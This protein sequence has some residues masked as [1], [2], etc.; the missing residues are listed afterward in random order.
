[1]TVYDKISVTD[2]YGNLYEGNRFGDVTRYRD[3]DR[4]QP[5]WK[6]PGPYSGYRVTSIA[7]TDADHTQLRVNWR[8][9]SNRT[10]T[11]DWDLTP[12]TP[13]LSKYVIRDVGGD[14]ITSETSWKRGPATIQLSGSTFTT[15]P[16]N[17]SVNLLNDDFGSKYAFYQFRIA[18]IPQYKDWTTIDANTKIDASGTLKVEVRAGTEAIS[19]NQDT[20]FFSDTLSRTIKLD[21]A[22][23]EK[24]VVS[25][26]FTPTYKVQELKVTNVTDKGVGVKSAGVYR[27]GVLFKALPTDNDP[28]K[29]TTFTAN[30]ETD[31]LT[32]VVTDK[33]DLERNEPFDGWRSDDSGPVITHSVEKVADPTDRQITVTVSEP[34]SYL[35]ALPADK[36]PTLM[37]DKS[38]LVNP[39]TDLPNKA[40]YTFKLSDYFQDKQLRAAANHTFSVWAVNVDG[41]QGNDD[42]FD[43]TIDNVKPE[44]PLATSTFT[45]TYHQ[46]EYTV[47]NIKDDDNGVGI[48][49]AD[50]YRDGVLVKSL[51][52]DRTFTASKDEIDTGL[53]SVKVTD[54]A[55][56]WTVKKDWQPP[57]DRT[58]PHITYTKKESV[59]PTNPMITVKVHDDE[60]PI[61]NS[62]VVLDGIGI[63]STNASIETMDDGK[64]IVYTFHL[65]HIIANADARAAWHQIIVHATNFD[66]Q[67]TAKQYFLKVYPDIS[68][69]LRPAGEGDF[70]VAPT[71]KPVLMKLDFNEEL[72]REATFTDLDS[73]QAI[74]FDAVKIVKLMYA[75]SPKQEISDAIPFYKLGADQFLVS[76][77]GDNWVYV[78]LVDNDKKYDE[79]TGSIGASAPNTFT[80][81]PVHVKIDY[82]Q[83]QY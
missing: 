82:N 76:K 38:I 53:I 36:K 32:I 49:T 31:K 45:S 66:D 4:E 72:V 5:Q 54:L 35:P 75:V 22:P 11:E 52:N 42:P 48:A 30:K 46:Y 69:Q 73:G 67:E 55:G 77:E 79:S 61:H 26:K 10:K 80:V 74:H 2:K 15:L 78:Q 71:D 44:M 47:S 14:S 29:S 62:S 65:D 34:E 27:D 20:V 23:P 33:F 24:P 21:S 63:D 28:N 8:N 81:G 7:L 58:I 18:S 59:D 64:T 70:S 56:N 39:S 37:I 13:P 9:G 25:A 16:E 57:S 6:V 41:R 17:S 51:L 19:G 12:T 1:V 3:G 40:V 68:A 43:L 50:L 60:S 83:N